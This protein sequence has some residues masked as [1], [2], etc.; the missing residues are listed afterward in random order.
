MKVLY[1]RTNNFQFDSRVAKE[2]KT[3]SSVDNLDITCLGWERNGRNSKRV[4]KKDIIISDLNFNGFL[5]DVYGPWGRGGRKN[6]I[7]LFVFMRVLKKWLKK[8]LYDYDAIHC[9]DLAT[10][11]YAIPIAKKR[12]IKII[13]DIF[14]YFP[15]IRK[16]PKIIRHFFVKAETKC[17]NNA[18]ITI[19]CSEERKKQI[20]KAKPKKLFVIHNSPD[21]NTDDYSSLPIMEKPI[22]FVYIGNLVNDRL[23]ELVLDY[24]STKQEYILNIGG[25]GALSEMAES[26]SKR[27]SNIKFFGALDY[28]KVLEIENASDVIIALYNP[29]VLNHKYVAS[30][31]FYEC[32]ALGKR[33]IMCAGTGMDSEIQKYNVG[34]L[35][36]PNIKSL[37]SGINLLIENKKEWPMHA[38]NLKEVFNNEYSWKI[39]KKRLLKIYETL[40]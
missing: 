24:F 31:K 30:N 33:I 21:I 3:L 18:D 10:A 23:I 35:I 20:G 15:D 2:L 19:I 16:Y 38:K 12:N 27:F 22:S 32:L 39:M 1:I 36:E 5:I 6:L 4:M 28:S 8:N 34:V 17:I 11:Y 25:I 40:E 9:V 7:P 29:E 37:N 14:D 26:Y 13:Y